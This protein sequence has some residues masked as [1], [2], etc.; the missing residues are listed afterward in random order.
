MELFI[1]AVGINDLDTV[2]LPAT[3]S[4]DIIDKK[5]KAGWNDILVAARRGYTDVCRV[6]LEK[7][8]SSRLNGTVSRY[9]NF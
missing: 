6:L 2:T 1:Q 4:P 5:D 9:K 8:V 3:T 7:G